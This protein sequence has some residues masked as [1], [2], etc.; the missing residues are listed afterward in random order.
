MR[1]APA[2]PARARASRALARLPAMSP[3]TGLS[4]ASASLKEFVIAFA[5]IIKSLWSLPGLTRQSSYHP[6]FISKWLRWVLDAR[7]CGHDNG[8]S[9][10]LA[11][12]N[13]DLWLRPH[14]ALAFQPLGADEGKL[15]RLVS[16]EPRVAMGVVAVR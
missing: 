6:R 11:G 4:C 8:G 5:I 14:F 7:F 10:L 2:S 15:E 9:Q 16:I 3:T 1:S 13:R 12:G